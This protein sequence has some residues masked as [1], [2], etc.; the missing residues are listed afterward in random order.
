MRRFEKPCFECGGKVHYEDGGTFSTHFMYHPTDKSISVEVVTPEE[1]N[2]YK[3]LGYVHEEMPKASMGMQTS[4]MIADAEAQLKQQAKNIRSKKYFEGSSAPQNVNTDQYTNDLTGMFTGYLQDNVDQVQNMRALDMIR[5]AAYAAS[6]IPPMFNMGGNFYDQY[7]KFGTFGLDPNNPRTGAW[8]AAY[9]QDKQNQA[10]FF[11]QLKE[12]LGNVAESLAKGREQTKTKQRRWA[13]SDPT[14]QS[15]QAIDDPASYRIWGKGRMLDEEGDFQYGVKD[16]FNK[17]RIEQKRDAKD[18]QK[19]FKDLQKQQKREKR[20]AVRE[21]SIFDRTPGNLKARGEA[22]QD[23]LDTKQAQ[24]DLGINWRRWSDVDPYDDSRDEQPT[25]AEAFASSNITGGTEDYFTNPWT[26]KR[27]AFGRE[28]NEYGL[29]YPFKYGGHKIISNNMKRRDQFG[30]MI[31]PF[32]RKYHRGG[33]LPT[34]GHSSSAQDMTDMINP[35]SGN[36]IRLAGFDPNDPTSWPQNAGQP[37]HNWQEQIG[38]NYHPYG[39]SYPGISDLGSNTHFINYGA[40]YPGHDYGA[41]IEGVFPEDDYPMIPELTGSWA[42]TPGAQAAAGVS[43]QDAWLW[44]NHPVHGS[45]I[46]NPALYDDR[47]GAYWQ[48]RRQWE[49]GMSDV[50]E[51]TSEQMEEAENT[52]P[53]GGGGGGNGGGGRGGN[54]AADNTDDPAKNY[55]DQKN[56]GNVVEGNVS[57]EDTD[58][59]DGGRGRRYGLPGYVEGDLGAYRGLTWGDD[60]NLQDARFDTKYGWLSGRPRRKSTRLRFH[61]P[62]P[63]SP[64]QVPVVTP[65]ELPV[66]EDYSAEYQDWFNR[67]YSDAV[68]EGMVRQAPVGY[69]QWMK[70]YHPEAP[71]ATR[72]KQVAPGMT[73]EVTE[74]AMKYGPDYW[75]GDRGEGGY[76]YVA[77]QFKEVYGPKSQREL[78][79]LYEAE[80]KQ[81]LKEE[82]KGQKERNKVTRGQNQAQKKINKEL[83]KQKELAERTIQEDKNMLDEIRA[84]KERQIRRQNFMYG[85]PKYGNGGNPKMGPITEREAM[86]ADWMPR[87]Q[88]VAGWHP[89]MVDYNTPQIPAHT[90]MAPTRANV[91]IPNP[92]YNRMIHERNMNQMVTPRIRRDGGMHMNTHEPRVANHLNNRRFE[93]SKIANRLYETGGQLPEEAVVLSEE[94][95]ANLLAAGGSV[96]YI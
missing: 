68:P 92:M 35:Q 9:G 34:H 18:L 67:M 61:S 36:R 52:T 33:N 7:D 14:G 19:E 6:G 60:T 16:I 50:E 75:Y 88:N 38:S 62:M 41:P 20:Q 76:E 42:V 78:D 12:N 46:G 87:G 3:S 45:T 94:E 74:P 21:H 27:D 13:T 26:V 70:D 51:T 24:K 44:Y 79:K 59:G 30:G 84:R 95:I 86:L 56:Q 91:N 82:R 90:L 43:P 49:P 4:P 10:N 73:E 39:A 40:K 37:L 63:G 48:N 25:T 5:K 96:K 54:Q 29:N 8:A 55:E 22:R 71:S 17:E 77:D 15:D 65:E 89:P 83:L 47:F 93:W 66:G 53:G 80:D 28:L 64:N 11:G 2:Y 85:G 23:L 72:T 31:N 81:R 69:D 32:R 1:H 57:D 58:G